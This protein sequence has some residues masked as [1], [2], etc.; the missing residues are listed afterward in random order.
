MIRIQDALNNQLYELVGGNEKNNIIDKVDQDYAV[1]PL[2]DRSFPVDI[3]D[4][5]RIHYLIRKFKVT[6]VL[7]FGSGKSTIVIADALMKNKREYNSFV[8]S[9]LRKNNPFELHTVESS[10]EWMKKTIS[11]LPAYLK[12]FVNTTVSDVSMSTLNSKICTLYEKL[13]NICP[14]FIYLDGPGQYDPI[15]SI[16]GITTAHPDRM[17]MVGDLIKIEHFLLP[18]TIILVDGRTANARFLLNNFQQDW[19]YKHY[20]D[21]DISVFVNESPPLGKYNEAELYFKIK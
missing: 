16:N 11:Q 20:F 9:K 17:P 8:E 3:N 2:Y 10:S 4:L 13:P 18:G 21:Q 19:A 14:D 6:T 12:H 15:N 5:V 7:E 1:D